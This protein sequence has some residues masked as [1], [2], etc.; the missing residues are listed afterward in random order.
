MERD[1]QSQG[2]EEG[3]TGTDVAF[4]IVLSRYSGPAR[5]TTG[6][7][8]SKEG[9]RE[10]VTRST[11]AGAGIER[12]TTCVAIEERLWRLRAVALFLGRYL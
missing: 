4:L 11:I 5:C 8:G 6:I 3:R 9:E 12:V 7:T 2:R 10:T 1:I